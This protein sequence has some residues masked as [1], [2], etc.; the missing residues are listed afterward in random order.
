MF[1]NISTLGWVIIIGMAIFIL[2]LNLGLFLGVKQKIKKNNWID[3][4]ADAGR[5]LKNPLKKENDLYQQLSDQV[6][7]LDQSK[8]IDEKEEH[9]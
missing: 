5:V 8:L 4:M 6:A 3:K 9:D 1:S 2:V 7:K